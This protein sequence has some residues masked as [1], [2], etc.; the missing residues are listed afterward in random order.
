MKS[1]KAGGAGG[2][3]GCGSV[4]AA[5]KHDED[6]LPF[7]CFRAQLMSVPVFFSFFFAM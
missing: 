6:L 1:E 2:R 3:A 5:Y 4:R 7:R